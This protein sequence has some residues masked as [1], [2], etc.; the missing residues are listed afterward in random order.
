MEPVRRAVAA[1]CVP[2]IAPFGRDP[3]GAPYN[4][5]A[6]HAA[7]HIA[8]ALGAERL[9]FLTDVPGIYRDFAAGNLLLDT[10][11]DELEHLLQ[12]GAFST[13]M[14]PKVQAMLYAARHGVREVWVVDG[15]DGGAVRAA[16]L[17]SEEKRATG[18]RLAI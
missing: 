2:V 17:G 18:T 14:I 12:T 1:G 6:D 15:R 11:T 9:V 16:V 7:S 5:N 10:T 8:R 3:S 13:G 4:I